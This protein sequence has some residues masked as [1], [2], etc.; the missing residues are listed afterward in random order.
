MAAN[1]STVGTNLIGIVLGRRSGSLASPAVQQRPGLAQ[2]LWQSR[3]PKGAKCL[4]EVEARL[5]GS[6]LRRRRVFARARVSDGTSRGWSS[7]DASRVGSWKSRSGGRNAL[8]FTDG[9]GQEGGIGLEALLKANKLLE[10]CYG[11]STGE[12]PSFK[13]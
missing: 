6:Q 2:P 8:R 9:Q 12:V 5:A 4:G 3:W 11:R 1:S 7:R 13:I 10:V